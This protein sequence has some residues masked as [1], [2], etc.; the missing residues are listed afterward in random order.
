MKKETIN[1][2][3]RTLN[4]EKYLDKLLCG[5]ESQRC[6]YQVR[7]TIVDSGSNDA[8]LSIARQHNCNLMHINKKEF[9]FGKSL[10]IG[11]S[12]T[13]SD[14]LVFISGHCVPVNGSWLERLI[15]PLRK[16]I[17]NYTY[18]KQMGGTETFWS[19]EKIF[20]KYFPDKSAIPQ[21]GFYCNNANS[22]ITYKTWK[23]FK[24]DENLT[25]LEDMKL[26]KELVKRG[27]KIGYVSEAK[28]YHYH[29]E[30][31]KQIKN[32]FERYYILNVR[33]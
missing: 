30:N 20:E 19:E 32:R 3:I 8:T 10:N 29:N 17:V 21:K 11:C 4:E 9:S 22:A 2:I 12:H 1:I 18:G 7:V 33:K 31:W 14:Y 24:F 26:A 15:E 16:G 23:E 27:M 13:I 25:G 28:I 6:S 5:I